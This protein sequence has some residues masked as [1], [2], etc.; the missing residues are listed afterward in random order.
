MYRLWVLICC[1]LLVSIALNEAK[2]Q[3]LGVEQ[4][5]IRQ[6]VLMSMAENLARLA[7]ENEAEDLQRRRPEP[8]TISWHVTFTK[9]P[10]L[11]LEMEE[12]P[13]LF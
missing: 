9:R 6:E 12:N 10:P 3:M 8:Y 13:Y 4:S 11:A 7:E 1:G 2:P 5:R